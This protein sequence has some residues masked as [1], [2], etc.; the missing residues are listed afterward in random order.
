MGIGKTRDDI[1]FG[2][3]SW[4]IRWWQHLF[5]EY[6]LRSSRNVVLY[7][8]NER[9]LDVQIENADKPKIKIM[10]QAYVPWKI[11]DYQV[12]PK[13]VDSILIAEV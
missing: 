7:G 5:E 11:I 8:I 4:K 3:L 10:S 9:S 1:F 2:E 6:H 12:I 13:G